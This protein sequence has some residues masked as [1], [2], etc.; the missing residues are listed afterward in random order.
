MDHKH[1]EDIVNNRLSHCAALLT[2]KNEEYGS[3]G[4]R[5]HNFKRAAQIKGC[6]P[7]EALDGMALKHE[8]SLRDMKDRMATQPDYVPSLTLVSEKIS[9]MINYLLLFEALIEERRMR[10]EV[11]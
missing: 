3:V 7:V 5:L 1:F 8:V 6:D 11:G 2:Q 4:D 10:G 9:D